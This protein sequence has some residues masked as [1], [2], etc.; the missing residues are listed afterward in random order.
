MLVI[1]FTIKFDFIHQMNYMCWLL[2]NIHH[3]TDANEATKKT[4]LWIFNVEKFCQAC[5]TYVIQNGNGDEKNKT[6]KYCCHK[7]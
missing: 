4:N 6:S 3:V 2:I 5:Y 7:D 1:G